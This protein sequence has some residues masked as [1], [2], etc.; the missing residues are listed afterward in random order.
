VSDEMTGN[1]ALQFNNVDLTVANSGK[2]GK[3]NPNGS[4]LDMK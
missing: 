4:L 3:N 2:L 1:L